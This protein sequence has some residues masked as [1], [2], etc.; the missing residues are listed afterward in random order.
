ML[1]MKRRDPFTGK[2]NVMT[3]DCTVEQVIDWQNGELS[4]NAFPNLN[5]DEREFIQTGIMPDTWDEKISEG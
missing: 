1:I 5:A 3:L 4:Q 2:E